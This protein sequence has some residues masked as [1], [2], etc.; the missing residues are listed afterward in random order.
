MRAVLEEDLV[1]GLARGDKRLQRRFFDAVS[2]E[3]RPRIWRLLQRPSA[4]E[5]DDLLHDALLA[6]CLPTKDRPQP[7]VLAPPDA[8]SPKAWRAKVLANF[9]RDQLRRRGLRAHV[10][11]YAG[12]DLDP[13]IV[14]EAWRQRKATKESA[15]PPE[16]SVER[17]E[18]GEGDTLHLIELRR[19]RDLIITLAGEQAIRRRMILLLAIDADP[20]AHTEALSK[21]LVEAV[22]ETQGRVELALKSPVEDPP[23]LPRVRVPWP[24][25]PEP[26]ARESA[27]KA[28]ERAIQGLREALRRRVGGE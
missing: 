25:E 3:W 8:R 2:D 18:D 6:L 22:T 28:L 11:A 14:K 12:R 4:E 17:A 15:P 24:V 7:R 23:S 9:V 21:E 26:K 10:E 16:L 20:S 27:R 1:L 19:Q 13:N 5:V